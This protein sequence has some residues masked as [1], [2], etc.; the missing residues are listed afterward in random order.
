MSGGKV[1]ER[2]CERAYLVGEKEGKDE[3]FQVR[4]AR[5]SIAAAI[6]YGKLQEI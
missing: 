1:W 6:A 5:G 3:A 2:N 4:S